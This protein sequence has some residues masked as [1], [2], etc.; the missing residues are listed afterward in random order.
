MI[1]ALIIETIPKEKSDLIDKIQ[2]FCPKVNCLQ[3]TTCFEKA[4]EVV[5]QAQTDL[6]FFPFARIG[7]LDQLPISSVELI[8]VG[9]NKMNAFEAIKHNVIGFLMPPFTKEDLM[10]C[11]NNARNR[12]QAK[13]ALRKK[14]KEDT[15]L[16]GIPTMEGLEFFAVKDIIRCE[17]FQKCTRLVTACNSRILSSYNIGEFRKILAPYDF[18]MPHKSFLINLKHIKKY[19]KEG[20]IIMSDGQGV[21]VSRRKKSEF[22]ERIFHL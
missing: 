3:P 1:N 21:P 6:V 5:N 18:Y 15:D 11:V 14:Q 20:T 16:L 12:I 8:C 22:L 9:N 7:L 4:A 19:H 13:S 10:G 2:E 17:G